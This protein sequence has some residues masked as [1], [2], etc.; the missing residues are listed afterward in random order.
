[1]HKKIQL[2]K[3]LQWNC[4]S[5]SQRLGELAVMEVELSPDIICLSET[6]LTD[7]STISFANYN[8][9]AYNRSNRSGGTAILIHKRLKYTCISAAFFQENLVDIICIE[10]SIN[11]SDKFFI[12]S[13]Y[14]PPRNSETYTADN[15][16]SG[17]MCSLA[18]LGKIIICGDFNGHHSL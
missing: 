17:L 9:V 2:I 12:C 14:S 16:W 6:K 5:L 7:S 13:L 18:S 10:L 1:M 15:L 8:M 11:A 3:V 4:R